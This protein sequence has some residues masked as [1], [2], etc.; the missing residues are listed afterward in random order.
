MTKSTIFAVIE[1]FMKSVKVKTDIITNNYVDSKTGEILEVEHEIKN[2]KIVVADKKGFA[3]LTFAVIGMLDGLDKTS[4][5]VIIWC[6]LNANYNSNII[7]LTK[8]YCTE[9]TKDFG[10]TYQTIKNSIGVLVKKKIL[11]PLGS[12]AYRINP[13]YFWKG[14]TT[15][16]LKMMSYVLNIECPNA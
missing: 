6:S 9:I 12:G 8:P 15:E 3:M 13:R 1:L 11:I 5:K 4:I 7:S 14:G 16:Q 10:I 2:H